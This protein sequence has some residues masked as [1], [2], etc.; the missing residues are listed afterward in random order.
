MGFCDD[1][2]V[3]VYFWWGIDSR[4]L[5]AVWLLTEDSRRCGKETSVS[6][7]GVVTVSGGYGR[8]P[9]SSSVPVPEF[10]GVDKGLPVSVWV[11]G[12]LSSDTPVRGRRVVDRRVRQTPDALSTFGSF[13]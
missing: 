8:D 5:G 2:F 1:E 10:T 13:W 7:G 12:C 4:H 3:G 11:F 6:S 9:G